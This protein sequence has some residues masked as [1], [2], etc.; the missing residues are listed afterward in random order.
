MSPPPGGAARAVTADSLF[1]A[2][3][4]T[5]PGPDL[6]SPVEAMLEARS[7]AVVGASARP[8]SFGEQLMIQL[9]AGGYGGRIH[10]VNPQYD[11]VMDLPCVP[12]LA[13]LPEPVDVAILGVSNRMLEEQLR[14]AAEAGARS[15][16]IFASCVDPET[17]DPPLADRLATIAR[18]A[19]MALCGGNGM[20]FVNFDHAFRACGFSEPFTL[21]PGGITFI[22]HSG[23]AFS[24]LLH[25][26]RGLAFNLAVSAGLELVTTAAEYLEFALSRPTTRVVAMFLE[27][28][29]DPDRFR[30]ALTAAA[31]R[32]VPVIALK[33]GRAAKA[34]A[35]VTAHS[36]ALAGAD[37]AYEALFDAHGVHRVETLDELCD[38]LELF[39]AGRPAAPGGL[40]A[41]HDSG[42]E[43]AH[44]VDM[45]DAGHV[46]LAE[47]SEA[48]KARLAEVLEPGLE[49]A[50]PLDAWGTGNEADEIFIA[51]MH[52]LLDDPDTAA[53]AFCV[54][55]TT[56]LV[57]ESGYTRVANEVF[58][59]TG[60][61]VAVLSN[62]AAAIDPR[63]AAF[64]R[65]QGMPILEG[66]VTGLAAFRHL[67]DHRDSSAR[68]SVERGSPSGPGVRDRWRARLAEGP[69]DEVDALALLADYGVPVVPARRVGSADE[70]AEAAD[71]VGWPVALKT[72]TP[73]IAHKSEADGVRLGIADREALREAYEDLSARLGPRA[74]VAAMA[75]PGVEL[76]LGVVRDEQ[77]GPMVMVAAGGVLVEALG[78]RRFGLPPV[79]E[80]GARRMLDRLTVRPILDGVRGRPP[81]DLAAVTAA[82]AR[83]SVLAEELGDHLRALDVNPLI[84]GPGGCVA[85]DALV[86]ARS[87]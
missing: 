57:P 68:P 2:D 85:V 19:G 48:T 39:A 47:I 77:F 33:V 31:E 4:A 45:A 34:R 6:R 52:A 74:V 21:T 87:P 28:V 46:P 66:T 86:V 35:M 43:R 62:M 32:D 83:L 67:F 82:V 11:T 81:A 44:L 16:V 14:A 5:A 53:L 36:G 54:D 55:L 29:R 58:A 79:D 9:T 42:G 50:N 71:G 70:A 3:T 22:T 41:I 25:N 75:P 7:V 23:S 8:D 72:A 69:L 24:A 61:P 38:T 80:P 10:P 18:G 49:P 63:D 17:T 84:A 76:A 1:M 13:D 65:G 56:E 15:A 40:A 73:G 59:R 27:T 37:G 78:D 60:K 51:C 26:R 30:A 12:S 64:V 20:G